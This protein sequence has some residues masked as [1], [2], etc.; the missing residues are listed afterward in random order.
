MPEQLQQL[1]ISYIAK[2]DRLLFRVRVG[3]NTEFRIWFTRRFTDLLL[4]LLNEKM[5]NYGGAEVLAVSNE[6]Q[7]DIKQGA[8]EK[9]YQEPQAPDYPFGE[10]GFVACQI[11]SGT[12][13]QDNLQLQILPEKGK[14]MNLKLDKKL[15]FMLHNLL[16]QGIQHADWNLAYEASLPKDIH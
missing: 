7:K 13:K 6:T 4:K 14:G 8:F 12:D 10:N 11:K 3:A 9:K 15:M 16:T 1:N 5:Q 2:E